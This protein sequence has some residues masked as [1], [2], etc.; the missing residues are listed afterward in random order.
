ME[1]RSTLRNTRTSGFTNRHF[2]QVLCS[3]PSYEE[4]SMDFY[5]DNNIL[6]PSSLQPVLIDVQHIQA[7][8]K[9]EHNETEC[10]IM[11]QDST[12]YHACVPYEVMFRLLKD[13]GGKITDLSTYN[14][15]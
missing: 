3:A 4:N 10:H 13:G 14:F 8:E 6:P 12:Q 2:I 7:I 5:E 9:C 15:G 11:M 1:N